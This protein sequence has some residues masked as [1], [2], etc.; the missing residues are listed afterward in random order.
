MS[1]VKIPK[2]LRFEVFKRD[3]FSCQYCGDKAPDAV[4]HV[5]HIDPVAN[6]GTNDILNLITSCEPCNLGKG[7][8]LLSDTATLDKQ[9][10]ELDE[11]ADRREQIEMMLKWRKELTDVDALEVDLIC[12]V[13]HESCDKFSVND[14][15][16]KFIK[17]WLKKYSHEELIAAVTAS[18]DSYHRCDEPLDDAHS[19]AW[20]KA[21]D[22]IPRIASVNRR[23][24]HSDSDRRIYYIRGILRNRVYVNER[25][26]MP[27]MRLAVSNNV[28]LDMVEALAKDCRNWTEFRDAVDDYNSG[29]GGDE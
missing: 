12:S 2:K 8:R 23:G 25:A 16:K 15:G 29:C 24:G 27:M 19:R 6:G 21:F 22:Y 18:F 11:L 14:S 4:L 5:D 3:K 9:R 7:A 26:Y 13:I 17:R 20:G 28:S 1:R 10:A